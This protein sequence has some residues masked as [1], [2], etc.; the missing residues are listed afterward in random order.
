MMRISTSSTD[1]ECRNCF[2]KMKVEEYAI[3]DVRFHLCPPCGGRLF[4]MRTRLYAEGLQS[5]EMK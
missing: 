4:N 2:S 3:D 1:R 5:V